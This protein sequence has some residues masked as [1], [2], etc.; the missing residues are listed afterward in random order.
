MGA[1][2]DI[3]AYA[4]NGY[5]QN[6]PSGWNPKMPTSLNGILDLPLNMDDIAARH[7]LGWG[8]NWS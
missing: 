2:I 4:P 6:A 3:N 7:G 8:G 1:A 5:A